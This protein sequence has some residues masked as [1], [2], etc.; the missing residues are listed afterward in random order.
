MG[1][2]ALI[3]ALQWFGVKEGN[4]PRQIS[5]SNDDPSFAARNNNFLFALPVSS[6]FVA[7]KFY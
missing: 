7:N 6:I 4:P 2:R 5:C 1:Q 3:N